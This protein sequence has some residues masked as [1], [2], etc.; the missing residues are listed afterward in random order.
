LFFF[1][2]QEKRDPYKVVQLVCDPVLHRSR[3]SNVLGQLAS[4]Y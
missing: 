1:N 3:R 4:F 2:F